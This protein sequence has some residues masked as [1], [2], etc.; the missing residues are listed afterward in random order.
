MNSQK[1]RIL[2]WLTQRHLCSTTLLEQRIPRG[3]ARILELRSDGWDIET[4]ECTQHEHRTRQVEYVLHNSP[5]VLYPE[6]AK[7]ATPP[8]YT[9]T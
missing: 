2:A 7:D 5:G 8:I 1:A 6:L 3:A 4:R 9:A